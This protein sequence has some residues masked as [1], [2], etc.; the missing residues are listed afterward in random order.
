MKWSTLV[1]AAPVNGRGACRGGVSAGVRW[2]KGA[3]VNRMGGCRGGCEEEY[4]SQSS[5][6]EQKGC[7]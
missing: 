2:V 1:R 7:V 6:C 5:S 4:V 3:H